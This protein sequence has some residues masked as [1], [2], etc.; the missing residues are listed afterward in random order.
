MTR[1]ICAV[2]DDATRPC[3][4]CNT[5]PQTTRVISRMR[6]CACGAYAIRKR[7]RGGAEKEAG[8]S[9]GTPTR[10]TA[11]PFGLLLPPPHYYYVLWG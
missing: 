1:L 4:T 8:V 11:S 5:T 2:Y 10:D 9:C 6:A 7:T 3:G